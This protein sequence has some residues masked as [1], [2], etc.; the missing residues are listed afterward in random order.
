MAKFKIR[1]EFHDKQ[2]RAFYTH[3][4]KARRY[5]HIPAFIVLAD[6][7]EQAHTI[8][9]YLADGTHLAYLD[10]STHPIPPSAASII[11]GTFKIELAGPTKLT[12]SG[13]EK[14]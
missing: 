7:V 1:V 9:Y 11:I 2:G 13:W 10:V 3:K 8:N 6:L 5:L 4:L 12:I 14:Q